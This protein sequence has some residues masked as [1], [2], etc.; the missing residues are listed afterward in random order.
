MNVL[1][2]D[3]EMYSTIGPNGEACLSVDVDPSDFFICPLGDTD[4]KF[5]LH[6]YMQWQDWLH[7]AM[8]HKDFGPKLRQWVMD[9][10]RAM[11]EGA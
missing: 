3:I 4:R 7:E 6:E 5:R 1:I 8:D 2:Y 11:E 10:V 9:Y